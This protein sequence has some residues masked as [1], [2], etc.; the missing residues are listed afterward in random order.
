MIRSQSTPQESEL[1]SRLRQL[2]EAVIQK[3][4]LVE[5]L[6]AEKSS[7]LLQ[8]ERMEVFLVCVFFFETLSL[9]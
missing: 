1:E 4:S 7:L 6:S 8:L 3:Q 9:N 5:T 2:T